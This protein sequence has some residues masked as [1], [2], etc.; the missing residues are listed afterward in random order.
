M[1]HSG[2]S[3]VVLIVHSRVFFLLT[4]HMEKK[5]KVHGTLGPLGIEKFFRV[6]YDF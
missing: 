2:I 5:V 3:S 1:P 6:K 4:G